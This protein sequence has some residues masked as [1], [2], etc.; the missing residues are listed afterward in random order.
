MNFSRNARRRWVDRGVSVLAFACVLIALLP[1]GS[2]LYTAAVRGASALTPSFFTRVGE[3]T[4][5]PGQVCPQGGIA[6]AIEGTFILVV[7]AALISLPIGILT[8]IYL[9]EYGNHRYGRTVRFFV[10]VMVGIPSIVIGI[11][12]F[13]LFVLTAGQG[14]LSPRLERSTIAGAIALAIIMIPIVAR[15]CD[16][17]LRL[18]PIT[19]REAALA[20]GIPRRRTILRIV[21]PSAGAAVLTGALLAVA[22]AAGETAP[23]ILTTGGNLFGFQGLDQPT[24]AMPLIIYTY[25]LSGIPQWV[26]DAWGAAFV[27]IVIMLAISVLSRL[28]L[29]RMLVARGTT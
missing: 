7:I 14:W 6:N 17:A 9:S 10:D 18:V 25:G 11:F 21:L 4:C 12:V 20:L 29:A 28:A 8:G 19:T 27:L 3:P 15:T 5:I 13:S 1:L 23:L 2:L 24:A 22:R 26:V 16:E